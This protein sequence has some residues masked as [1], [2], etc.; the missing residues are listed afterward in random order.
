MNGLYQSLLPAAVADGLA[1]GHETT[2]QGGFGHVV[3][4]PNVVEKLL[5]GHE[6]FMVLHE[7]SEDIEN[8]RLKVT[9][10]APAAQLKSFEVKL[11]VFEHKNHARDSPRAA[12]STAARTTQ[13]NEPHSRVQ[14]L[15]APVYAQRTSVRADAR[16]PKR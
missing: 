4:R 15:R 5:L 11:E 3:L 14:G 9:H 13:P 12:L 7:V 16:P 8:L 6:S 1:C 2:V 10:L